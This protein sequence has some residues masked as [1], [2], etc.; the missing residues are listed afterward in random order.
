MEARIP[1]YVQYDVTGYEPGLMQIERDLHVFENAVNFFY[2]D[3][4]RTV[5]TIDKQSFPIQNAA[6]SIQECMQ[7]IRD[8]REETTHL[9]DI[10]IHLDVI[11]GRLGQIRNVPSFLNHEAP[12]DLYAF[13]NECPTHGN[14]DPMTVSTV[15]ELRDRAAELEPRLND[16]LPYKLSDIIQNVNEI[17][18]RIPEPVYEFDQ[19][20]RAR[21]HIERELARLKE[22]RDYL[23][24]INLKDKETIHT[25]WQC[26]RG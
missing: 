20:G 19:I 15:H 14:I 5:G 10:E 17:M 25:V 2:D 1:E 6:E 7:G 16:D 11:D 24:T 8:P 22:M 9:N 4:C 13:V 23:E 21:E 18:Q 3:L 12:W 26:T